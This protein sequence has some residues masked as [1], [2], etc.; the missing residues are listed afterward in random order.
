MKYPNSLDTLFKD[1]L[2]GKEAYV[3]ASGLVLEGTVEEKVR[4]EYLN[5]NGLL[6]TGSLQWNR[7]KLEDGFMTT[8]FKKREEFGLKYTDTD[9]IRELLREF[10]ESN[11]VYVGTIYYHNVKN[12]TTSQNS[13][14]EVTGVTINYN[15]GN[16]VELRNIT[17]PK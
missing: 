4:L 2:N 13:D 10:I 1:F 12:F 16:T 7:F 14:G 9:N 17:Q 3:S 11:R 8:L 5:Y 15:N 6:C